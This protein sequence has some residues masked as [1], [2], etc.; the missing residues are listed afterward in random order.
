TFVNA[1][2]LTEGYFTDSLKALGIEEFKSAILSFKVN[3]KKG[4]KF[5]THLGEHH[6][7]SDGI[8][9]G[10][11]DKYL[12]T[13]YNEIEASSLALKNIDHNTKLEAGMDFGDMMSFVVAQ[14][15]GNYLYLLKEFYTLP[16]ENSKE[17]A[18]KFLDFF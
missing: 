2:I 18:M 11:Y 8:L 3:I 13:D 14:E 17:L 4:E 6:F 7:Y 16:P 9:P 12:L 1:D 5:Y 15:R 10:Y